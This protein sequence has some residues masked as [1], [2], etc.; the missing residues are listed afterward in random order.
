MGIEYVAVIAEDHYKAFAKILVTT[1]LPR[2]YEMWL[3]VRDRGNLRAIRERS[4]VL[5]EIKIS[6]EE[7][8]AYCKR[9]KRPDFSIS[10]LDRC[11]REKGIAEGAY[12]LYAGRPGDAPAVGSLSPMIGPSA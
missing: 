1:T 2:D 12:P 8:G 3:R 5:V 9:M 4:A 11:A 7:L 6:P 10:T